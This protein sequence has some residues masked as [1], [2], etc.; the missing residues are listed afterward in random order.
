MLSLWP[1][2]LREHLVGGYHLQPTQRQDGARQHDALHARSLTARSQHVQRS[3]DCRLHYLRLVPRFTYRERRR[4]VDDV[5]AVF[6]GVQPSSR[7]I[8]QIDGDDVQ[9][10]TTEPLR[11]LQRLQSLAVP[12]RS[13]GAADVVDAFLQ[14]LIDDVQTDVA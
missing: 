8:V 12:Q 2:G 3:L 5:R 4:G 1:V 6:D 11:R 13:H 9:S 14:Q 7:I 10:T